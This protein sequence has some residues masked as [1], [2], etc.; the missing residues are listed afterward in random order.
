MY[1]SS[2]SKVYIRAAY[3]GILEA[4]A[5]CAVWLGR[6]QGE[7]GCESDF[8]HFPRRRTRAGRAVLSVKG[9]VAHG[10]MPSGGCVHVGDTLEL[11]FIGHLRSLAFNDQVEANALKLAESSWLR[12]RTGTAPVF[13]LDDVLSEL[14]PERRERLV[15]ALP[16]DAQALVTSALPA[17]LPRPAARP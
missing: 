7:N 9:A 10:W 8:V 1:Q 14:D 6:A 12:D 13:L 17:G 16:G 3:G 2:L 15:G 4:P 11:G 5:G